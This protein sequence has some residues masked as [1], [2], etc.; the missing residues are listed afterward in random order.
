MDIAAL[1][2]FISVAQCES[3]SRASEALHLTQPAV[4]KRVAAL[5]KELST[6]LFN[7]INRQIS[8]TEAGR[9]LLPRAMDL[10]E[11]AR[12]IQ[13]FA[14][15][16]EQEVMGALKIGTSH[17][18]G[19]HRL[20]PIL[21][22]YRQRYPAVELD[23]RFD[24]S[25]QASLD[26]AR[27]ELELAIVT[28]PAQTTE[29]LQSEIIWKDQLVVVIGPGHPLQGSNKVDL[30]QLAN[31]PC[32]FPDES[33]ETYKIMR[34][35]LDPIERSL[36]MRMSTNNLETLKMLVETGF[37]WSLLPIT[38]L[39]DKKAKRLSVLDINREVS[40]NLG[41]ISHRKRTASN[42]ANAL[43]KMIREHR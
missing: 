16:L 41:L 10:V 35:L 37:G 8:L 31:Y 13:R 38:M 24:K 34:R 3:F 19:L 15:S 17:H 39:Q 14:S 2:A 7:R 27:G 29:N 25:E 40:R 22:E 21:R 26:V 6:Q 20:P 32:V 18:I 12:D 23:I 30:E 28:L 9:Q 36:Q 33:T 4:S 43:I 11:Q 42:A 5:E 1:Q